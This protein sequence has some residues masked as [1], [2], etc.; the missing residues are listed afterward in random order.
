M[1][2]HPWD[3]LDSIISHPNAGVSEFL[4][5]FSLELPP[6]EPDKDVPILTRQTI[7]F[8]R[9]KLPVATAKGIVSAPDIHHPR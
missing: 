7:A 4:P 2:S 9:E 3:R 6:S 1:Q 5:G 8:L